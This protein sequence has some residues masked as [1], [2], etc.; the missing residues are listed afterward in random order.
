VAIEEFL[1]AWNENPRPFVW[2]ATVQK[3]MDK[4]KRGRV[5]LE[6]TQPGGRI[7]KNG[8]S[9]ENKNKYSHLWG[10]TLES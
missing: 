3:I 1:R 6:T 2:T 7:R 4:I 10:T 9:A 8:K 5:A